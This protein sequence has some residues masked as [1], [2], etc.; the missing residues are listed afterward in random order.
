MKASILARHPHYRRDLI[1]EIV[2]PAVVCAATFAGITAVVL[3]ITHHLHQP[4]AG[5]WIAGMAA[6]G[7][8][9]D[10]LGDRHFVHLMR[11]RRR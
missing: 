3:Q 7:T 6:L 10:L 2:G 8:V 5:W 9:S 4:C 1:L 11:R